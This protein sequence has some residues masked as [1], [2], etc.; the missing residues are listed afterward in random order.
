MT[1]RWFLAL[2]LVG[3]LAAPKPAFAQLYPMTPAPRSTAPAQLHNAAV[4]RAIHERFALGLADE[5]A[6]KNDAAIA[7]FQAILALRP[8]E[9]QGSTAHYDLALAYAATQRFDEAARELRAAIILDPG[10]LAA[11][12]NLVAVDL[13]RNDLR[14][15]RSVAD[16]FASLAP[17]SARALYSHGLVALRSGD[18]RSAAADFGRLIVGNPGYAVAHV[19]LA[20]AELELNDSASAERE[21][22]TALSLAPTYAYARFTLGSILL[23]E[24]RRS[25][26]RVAFDR[27]G[28]D[29]AG[30]A[31]L[32]NLA[33]SLRD[34]IPQ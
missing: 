12:A 6:G 26:A 34:S 29:A 8:L 32:Q 27:A 18:A 22:L 24:G 30:D 7:E 9:P 21:A 14:E 3:G 19:E 2:A 4:D 16:R 20:K 31:Q 23:H 15:A 25:E 13:R 10:F 33:F 5:S 11:M 17:D 1:Q 28:H